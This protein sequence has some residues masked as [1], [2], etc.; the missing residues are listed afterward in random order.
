M[1]PSYPLMRNYYVTIQLNELHC[2]HLPPCYPP[3]AKA[4][5][6]TILFICF[7]LPSNLLQN[8]SLATD[9]ITLSLQKETC[10]NF[11][12]HQEAAGASSAPVV[13]GVRAPPDP[14]LAHLHR[15][16]RRRGRSHELLRPRRINAGGIGA[17]CGR[18][19]RWRRRRRRITAE[20]DE[21][22]SPQA[23]HHGRRAQRSQEAHEG[24]DRQEPRRPASGAPH[25]AAAADDAAP[26]PETCNSC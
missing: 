9:E 22:L 7:S 3:T 24:G 12:A 21:L 2:I 15:A 14:P 23:V 4:K 5:K 10:P 6:L 17:A 25:V 8:F 19:L 20:D 11:R 16:D 26:Q 18:R 13:Y 1:I